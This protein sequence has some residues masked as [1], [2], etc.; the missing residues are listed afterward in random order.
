MLVFVSFL[1]GVSSTPFTLEYFDEDSFAEI[2]AVTSRE[3]EVVALADTD[4][5]PD[6]DP[7]VEGKIEEVGDGTTL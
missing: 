7:D 1:M 6:T 2:V 4:T 5:D 3:R